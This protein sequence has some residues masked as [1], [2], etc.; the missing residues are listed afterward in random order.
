MENDGLLP[1]SS[2]SVSDVH[3][4]LS[5]DADVSILCSSS[6]VLWSLGSTAVDTLNSKEGASLLDDQSELDEGG[7]TS[8][9][10]RVFWS[11]EEDASEDEGELDVSALSYGGRFRLFGRNNDGESSEN[12]NIV[13]TSLLF[14]TCRVHSASGKVSNVGNVPRG[15]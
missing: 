12:V 7:T 6:V 10:W 14:Q 9:K 5:P 2:S 3:T 11:V 4:G 15:I 8:S 13:K 1:G